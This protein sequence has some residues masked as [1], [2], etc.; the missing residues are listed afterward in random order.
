[1][2]NVA[3]DSTTQKQRS[4]IRKTLLLA[5][6]AILLVL[7]ATVHKYTKPVPLSEESLA[8][9]GMYYFDLPRRFTPFELMDKNNLSVNQDVFKDQWSLVFF[10]FTHCPDICPTTLID[11]NDL[12]SSIPALTKA[13]LNTT[14]VTLDPAR[15]TASILKAY[16]D[17]FNPDFKTLTG[18]FL[19]IRRFANELNVPFSKVTLEQDYTI[20]HGMQIILL[21]PHGDFQGFFKPPFD[22]KKM[23]QAIIAIDQAFQY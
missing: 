17:A 7:A 2:A 14:F 12:M 8:S 6:I 21:N 11:L 1:M 13:P 9:L 16:V 20:D 18:D 3:I 19:T 5:A 10:G 22:L 4:G 15:D 23:Q